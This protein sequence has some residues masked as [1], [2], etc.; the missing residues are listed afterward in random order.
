MLNMLKF[1]RRHPEMIPQGLKGY[2]KQGLSPRMYLTIANYLNK[3]KLMKLFPWVKTA[4]YSAGFPV[5]FGFAFDV[6]PYFP[7]AFGA[8][9]GA[10]ECTVPAIEAAEGLG[11]NHDLCSYMKTSIGASRQGWPEDFGGNE[12][13]D[14]YLSANPVCDTHMKWFEGDAKIFGKPHFG[15]DVPSMVE[16]E[17][18]ERFEEYV[19]YLEAQYMDLIAFWERH[20]GRK[21]DLQKFN[22]AVDKSYELAHL[23]EALMEYRKRFPANQYFHWQR[24][25]MLPLVCQWNQ[26]AGI[27]FYRSELKKAQAR[28]G[29]QKVIPPGREPFRIGWDGITLWYKVDFYRKVLAEKGAFVVAESYTHSFAIRKKPAAVTLKETLRQMAREFLIVPYTL[30]ID[31]RIKYFDQMI[32]DYDLDGLILFANQ[33]CRPQA[34]GLQDLRDALVEKWGIPILIL[35]T[36]HCDPRAYADGPIRTRV[37]GFVEMMA[38]NQRRGRRRPTPEPVA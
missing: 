37:D 7:E 30:N 5:E 14:F 2:A 18:E 23:F 33:S 17:G 38:S 24:S 35:N 10:A 32:R 21:F 26:D 16:G 28:Y 20:T 3:T 31:L 13:T 6:Y 36:D 27:R 15:L 12:P 9:T 4:S 19:D 1:I 8:L 22:A 25:F 34:T 11:Y 29:D